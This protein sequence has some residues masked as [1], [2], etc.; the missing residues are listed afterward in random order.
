MRVTNCFYD[1]DYDYI[2]DNPLIGYSAIVL[3]SKIFHLLNC[4]PT[5]R[6]TYIIYP[7]RQERIPL[8]NFANFS[9]TI[10]RYDIQ[11]YTLVS[12][13]LIRKC[14][15][16]HYITYIIDKNALLLVMAI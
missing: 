10:Q 8:K 12:H 11:F 6:F 9:R 3:H 16:F 2:Y 7:A 1:Y 5:Y 13:S 14:G 4:L 15:K